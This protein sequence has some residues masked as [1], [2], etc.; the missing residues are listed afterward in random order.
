MAIRIYILILLSLVFINVRGQYASNI[1]L[2]HISLERDTV[3]LDSLS[4]VPNTLSLHTASG[5]T[6]DSTAYDLYPFAS[7]LVWRHKPQGDTMFTASFRVY[8]YALANRYFN[9]NHADYVKAN[10]NKLLTP[11]TYTPN[12][13][14]ADKLID[15]GALDYN[16]SFSRGLG[17][18]STQSV[19]LSSSFNMQLQGMLTP[20]LEITAAITDNNIPIQPEGNTQSIQEFDKIFIQLRYKIHTVIVGD[21]DM[22]SPPTD[23]FLHYTKKAEGG[24][25]NGKFDFKKNGML[26]TH[27]AGGISKGSY[28]TNTITPTEGNQ[29]PYSLTG[30]N[31]ETYVIVLANTEAVYING[32]RLT[33]GA[34]QDYVIDYNSGRITFTPKRIITADM[35][36]TVEFEYSQLAYQ[37]SMIDA[38]MDYTVGK[39]GTFFDLYSEQDAKNQGQNQTLNANQKSFLASLGDSTQKAFYTGVDTVGWNVNQVLYARHDTFYMVNGSIVYDTAYAYSTD[40]TKAI[41]SITFALVGSGLG[42]YNAA[43]STANGSV[44]TYSPKAVIGVSPNQQLTHTGSYLPIVTLVAPQLHQ[45]YTAGVSYQI[46]K[47]NKIWKEKRHRRRDQSHL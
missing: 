35:R 43:Q 28:A 42:D 14:S 4:M 36:I 37:R 6:I 46:D 12:E 2:K 24:G 47:H 20:D 44:Y 1:K 13:V 32:T 29:G 5:Q 10:K 25:Y 26:K 19:T 16:G 7:L 40:S 33:R 3:K 38:R 31:G 45:M 27:V 41:Y 11:F 9:K 23:Y 39:L 17:F 8:P 34:N 15:F 21:F 30:A 18:G 22:N